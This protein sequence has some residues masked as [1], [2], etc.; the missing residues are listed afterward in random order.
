MYISQTVVI[1]VH[2]V[3]TVQNAAKVSNSEQTVSRSKKGTALCKLNQALACLVQTRQSKMEA[4]L[5]AVGSMVQYARE[6]EAVQ[7]QTVS[8]LQEKKQSGPL[9]WFD[10]PW[11]SYRLLQHFVPLHMREVPSGTPQCTGNSQ[12]C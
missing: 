9:A 8:L 1:T 11:R 7:L 5:A 6:D 10:R 2:E 4:F 3:H 12:T